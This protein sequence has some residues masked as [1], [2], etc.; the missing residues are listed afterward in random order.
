MA[1][2]TAVAASAPRALVLLCALALATVGRTSPPLP[3]NLSTAQPPIHAQI[4]HPTTPLPSFEVATIKPW[5]PHPT[6]PPPPPDATSD[7]KPARPAKVAPGPPGGQSTDRVHTI[8]PA[9]LLIAF[10]YNLPAG[11]ENRI[12]GGPAWLN[13][14]DN[15]FEIAAKI[16]DAAFAS[17]QKMTPAQQRTQVDLMEQSLLADRFKLKVHF[18]TR[19]MPAYTLVV[20]RGGPKL[21]PAKDGET[22]KLSFNNVDQN[23]QMTAVATT[24]DQW[25]HSPFLAGRNIV[26]QTGLTGA[27]DFTL[28]WVP[29]AT[30]ATQE[31]PSD[32]PTFF[33]AIQKQLGLKLVPAKVP[34]EV[35]AIDHIEKPSAN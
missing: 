22:S 15:Q 25:I 18:E 11:S 29:D 24:L 27:Y 20:A 26:D 30:A 16:D 6:P 3:P 19:D 31:K 12:L 35:I 1:E 9:S 33:T 8:L 23:N 4:L 13:D 7:P 2:R 34:V 14:Q 10:A 28:T 32:A 5:Q 21:T 17:M